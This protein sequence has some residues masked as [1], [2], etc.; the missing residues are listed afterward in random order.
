MNS[1][2]A[3]QL[4]TFHRIVLWK[5]T[6]N[7]KKARVNN[8]YGLFPYNEGVV[9]IK[10]PISPNFDHSN[11]QVSDRLHTA[12]LCIQLCLCCHTRSVEIGSWSHLVF[13]AE[14]HSK[15]LYEI[16]C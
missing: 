12:K 13:I 7:I 3:I 15:D 5:I 4:P 14:Y 8:N 1:S 6:E 16:F 10:K 11:S 2:R 9:M